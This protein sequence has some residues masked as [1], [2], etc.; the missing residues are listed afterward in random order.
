MLYEVITQGVPVRRL[1]GG[2]VRARLHP[3]RVRHPAHGV[4]LRAEHPR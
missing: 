4:Q 2:V 1:L 3:E